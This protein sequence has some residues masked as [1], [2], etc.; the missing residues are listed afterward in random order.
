M[1][2]ITYS[3]LLDANQVV[4]YNWSGTDSQGNPGYCVCAIFTNIK[5][6]GSDGS[7]RDTQLIS[8][9]GTAQASVFTPSQ[10]YDTV[11]SASAGPLLATQLQT[12]YNEAV[13]TVVS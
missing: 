10:I 2:T 4:H 6:L 13:A 7:V 11:N 3:T 5:T 12:A 8:P 1:Q 9:V